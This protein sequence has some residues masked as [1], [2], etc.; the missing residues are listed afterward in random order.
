MWILPSRGRPANVIR[1]MEAFEKTGATTP[2]WLRFDDDDPQPEYGYEGWVVEIGPRLPLSEIYAEAYRKYPYLPWYGFIADDVVPTTPE[3]DKLLIAAAGQDG[4]AFGDDGIN[5]SKHA[6][7][8]VLG[9]NLVR[10]IGW[11]SLP[12]L[13]RIYI[14]NVWNEIAKRLG[15]LR[16]MPNIMLRHHH[17]SNHL[18][19][20]DATYK[21]SAEIKE[22]DK[23]IYEAWKQHF[24]PAR[25]P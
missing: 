2:V 21:K 17:F 25:K 12:G 4:M 24:Q 8:F 11:L 3:W 19:L 22:N 5:G 1:L 9:G 13:A 18:A 7:H 20:F 23:R 16:Y 6:T 14:D 15:V 10:S